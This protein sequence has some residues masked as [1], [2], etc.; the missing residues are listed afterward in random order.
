MPQT[1]RVKVKGKWYTVEVGSLLERPVRALVDG[2]RWEREKD[3]WLPTA[4]DRAFV[5]S[6][7]IPV[8]DP[9]KVAGWI[10]PPKRGIHGR[11][12]DYDYVRFH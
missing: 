9:G 1:L 5:R 3:A 6:L 12:F 7:M 2:E 10:A 4:D 11:P 8:T